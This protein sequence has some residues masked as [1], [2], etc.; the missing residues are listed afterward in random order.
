MNRNELAAA[1]QELSAAMGTTAQLEERVS[2]IEASLA[3]QT[4][5][6]HSAR[7]VEAKLRAKVEAMLRGT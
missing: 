7:I 3:E 5:R 1:L 6:L 2:G 4:S